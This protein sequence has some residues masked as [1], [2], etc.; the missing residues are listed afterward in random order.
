MVFLVDRTDLFCNLTDINTN[1]QIPSSLRVCTN[2]L[3]SF[4]LVPLY[5][6]FLEEEEK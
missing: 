4:I 2:P 3:P 1:L 6:Y 5:F